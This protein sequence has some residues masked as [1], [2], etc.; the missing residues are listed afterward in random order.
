MN[1]VRTA[2]G[3]EGVTGAM[4]RARIRVDG[5]LLFMRIIHPQIHPCS[6]PAGNA[7]LHAAKGAGR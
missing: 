7:A 2:E 1:G 4:I 5:K 6:T 3:G